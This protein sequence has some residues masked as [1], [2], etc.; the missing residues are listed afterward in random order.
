MKSSMRRRITPLL[1]LGLLVT[2]A[3]TAD[4]PPRDQAEGDSQLQ[5]TLDAA[6]S[7]G[8]RN[9]RMPA[10]GLLTAGQLTEEQFHGLAAAGF[11]NFISLRLAEEDGA[12]WEEGYAPGEGVSFTRVPVPGGAGLN[13][14]TAEELAR[15]LDA[16][17]DQGTVLYCGSSNR[18]GAL[19]ALKAFWVDGAT[20]EEALELGTASGMT[21]L[22]PA[23]RQMLG[24]SEN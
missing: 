5:P 19:M 9:A 1:H 2:V 17:G 12:G 21:R 16:A 24:L 11:Q 15:L 3:C 22:E 13:R 8:V 10:P 20:P 23:V 7:L 4:Q 6:T 18:V 14:E